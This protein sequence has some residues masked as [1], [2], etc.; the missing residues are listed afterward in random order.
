[1]HPTGEDRSGSSQRGDDLL[2]RLRQP[3]ADR[4]E[5]E[6]VLERST[7][8][9]TVLARDRKH[10]R[11]VVLKVLLPELSAAV[12]GKRFLREI[13][14]IAGL[15]HPHILTLID[16]GSAN[17]LHW[18]V[19]PHVEGESLR[20]MLDRERQLPVERALQ[21]AIDVADQAGVTGGRIQLEQPRHIFSG[22]VR[23]V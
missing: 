10:G 3:L 14:T 22:R 18:Y 9:W 15:G 6:S 21:I 11:G 16:S 17:G 7:I 19:V 20:K 13:D 12:E 2:S 23:G 4:Y 1:M 5:L 8:A